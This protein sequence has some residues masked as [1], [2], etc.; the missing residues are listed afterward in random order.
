[1]LQRHERL[2]APSP[3]GHEHIRV[4]VEDGRI[5]ILPRTLGLESRPLDAQPVRGQPHHLGPVK[6][7]LVSVPEIHRPARALHLPRGLP[8]IPVVAGLPVPVVTALVLIGAG[9]NAPKKL[10]AHRLRT[11][12]AIA[13]CFSS[14]T[15]IA[16]CSGSE[17]SV[18]TTVSAAFGRPIFRAAD[19]MDFS[20]PGSESRRPT[21]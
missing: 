7:L 13:S 10:F 3:Q 18:C 21:L 6:V 12:S 5:E 11:L 9:R 19:C 4:P 17:S 1:M 20:R 16:S 14:S 15:W 8:L 2:E